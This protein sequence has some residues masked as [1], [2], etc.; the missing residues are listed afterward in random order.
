MSR[1]DG[2]ASY[3][4]G[5]QGFLAPLEWMPPSTYTRDGGSRF[6]KPV[7]DV[8][9][10]LNKRDWGCLNLTKKGEHSCPII[11]QWGFEYPREKDKKGNWQTAADLRKPWETKLTIDESTRALINTQQEAFLKWFGDTYPDEAANRN[12][13]GVISSDD[14]VRVN[15]YFKMLHKNR[16]GKDKTSS[17]TT[18]TKTKITQKNAENI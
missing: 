6:L 14:Q 10:H 17:K 8:V 15:I 4:V 11:S 12:F 18:S 7:K 16:E 9:F 3:F 1:V 2:P 5:E 13:R